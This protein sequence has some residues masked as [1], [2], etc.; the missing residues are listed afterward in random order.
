MNH[1]FNI[2][3]QVIKYIKMKNYTTSLAAPGGCLKYRK[4]QKIGYV[5]RKAACL[6]RNPGRMCSLQSLIV[7]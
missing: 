3:V 1:F 2:L 4:I 6:L 7:S 5:K